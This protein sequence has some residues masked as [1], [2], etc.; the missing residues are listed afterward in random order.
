M[1]L[2]VSATSV[3][4]AV[5][6]SE[7]ASLK[8]HKA[9]TPIIAGSICGAVILIAYV[10]GFI[11]YLKRRRHRR[12]LTAKIAADATPLPEDTHARQ[13]VIIPPDPAVVLGLRQPGERVSLTTPRSPTL[14]SPP[15][16]L[17][18]INSFSSSPP[19]PASIAPENSLH[20][21]K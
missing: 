4:R 20:P 11:V 15:T 3:I 6:P 13:P 19:A 10:A 16:T 18:N 2:R 21:H 8:G 5:S 17:P 14:K 12:N 7:S 1:I 9:K